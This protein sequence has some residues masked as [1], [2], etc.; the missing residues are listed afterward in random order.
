M[1]KT[2]LIGAIRENKE[3]EA[4]VSF[5]MREIGEKK[6]QN[7]KIELETNSNL[8]AE[9]EILKN[10]LSS[11]STELSLKRKKIENLQDDLAVKRER[12]N[13]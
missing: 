8:Q 9:V 11:D 1:E 7:K 10:K 12:L 2:K 13:T 5:L 6:N 4:K 3:S